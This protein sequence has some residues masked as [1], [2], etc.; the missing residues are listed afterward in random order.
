MARKVHCDDAIDC[1][2]EDCRCDDCDD[3]FVDCDD[4]FDGFNRRHFIFSRSSIATYCNDDFCG[5]VAAMG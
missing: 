5:G 3:G 1:F 2:D 4:G